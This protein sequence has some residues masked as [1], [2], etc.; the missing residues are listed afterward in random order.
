M[1]EYHHRYEINQAYQNHKNLLPAWSDIG[2][3]AV[4]ETKT[5]SNGKAQENTGITMPDGK[6][7]IQKTSDAGESHLWVTAHPEQGPASG[8]S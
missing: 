2:T 5:A 8:S 1:L 4:P 7:C 3:V 6:D